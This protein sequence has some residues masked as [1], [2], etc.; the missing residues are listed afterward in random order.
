[1]SQRNQGNITCALHIV[2]TKSYNT[3][4]DSLWRLK[5]WTYCCTEVSFQF[6]FL[7]VFLDLTLIV[8]IRLNIPLLRNWCFSIMQKES[9]K[10][11]TASLVSE[12]F[13]YL[14]YSCYLVTLKTFVYIVP[15]EFAHS[16]IVSQVPF[17]FF[18]WG[19]LY[20]CHCLTLSIRQY[21]LNHQF[22]LGI[23]LLLII[24]LMAS[25]GD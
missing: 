11:N 1:M 12:L 9:V 22:R 21:F 24:S 19:K 18:Y 7:R 8:T 2:F 15:L 5:N 17:F 13:L 3:K 14:H 16:H 4:T 20:N 23:S 6:H 25:L 10:E